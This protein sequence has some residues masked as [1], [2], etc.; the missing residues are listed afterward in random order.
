MIISY[1]IEFDNSKEVNFSDLITEIFNKS[2]EAGRDVVRQYLEEKDSSLLNNRDKSRYRCKGKRRTAVK[3]KLG[4]IDYE[5][6]I[7]FDNENHEHV[8]LLDEQIAARSIG[9]VDDE[10]CENISKMI[11]VMPYRKVSETIN[12]TT[13]LN[14]S[15]QAVWNIAQQMGS[16]QITKTKELAE[17]AKEN[18]LIGEVETKLLY[19]ESDGDWL[20][21]QGK[22]RKRFGSSKEMK[23]GIAYDGV[24][25][26]KQKSG[27]PRRELDNKVAYA[28]FEAA[29]DFRK[30]KEAVIAS[31]YNIDEIQT[32]VKNGDGAQW[33]QKSDDECI[34]V[35]DAYH[36]NKK[37]TECVSDKKIAKELRGLLL[38]GRYSELLDVTEAYANSVTD[39]LQA[40][41]LREL[42]QY[43]SENFEALPGYYERG[44]KI[45]ETREPGVIHHARLGSMESNVFT[46]IGNRMKGGRACWSISGGNNLAALLCKYYTGSNY[47]FTIE[48]P[49]TNAPISAG[50]IRS[51]S[52]KG[53][54]FPHNIHFPPAY[55]SIA[56]LSHLKSLTD[57]NF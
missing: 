27:K 34:C 25:F 28:S 40:E 53:Y 26:H 24:I 44:I 46:L 6:R 56:K 13:G 1:E 8:Y 31:R 9:L 51:T 18:K 22:D 42:H 3:T 57:L 48:S 15:H 41:K 39:E 33:I 12:D 29:D 38:S 17:L 55:K 4:V 30:H 49:K 23:I 19:E 52:G 2:M 37:I 32:R 20:K 43:Y 45:P 36:R 21:L 54:E 47:N 50:K 35:L 11:C 7:Y 14:V 10:M 16:D 5:R